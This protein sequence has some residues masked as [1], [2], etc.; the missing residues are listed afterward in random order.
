MGKPKARSKGGGAEKVRSNKGITTEYSVGD[1]LDK[2]EGCLDECQ[3]QLAQ[4]FCQRA[5]EMDC[6]NLRALELRQRTH[7]CAVIR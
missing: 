6:D 7:N 4:K 3:F 2:A 5:L 1:I